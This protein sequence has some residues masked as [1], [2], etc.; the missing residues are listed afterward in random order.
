MK[1][2]KKVSQKELCRIAAKLGA[3]R[4]TRYNCHNYEAYLSET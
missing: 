4:L 1:Y 2:S 3:I